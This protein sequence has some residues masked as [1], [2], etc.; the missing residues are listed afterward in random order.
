[1]IVV[2]DRVAKIAWFS[3]PR[4]DEGRVDWVT[5]YSGDIGNTLGPK[6]L[7]TGSSLHVSS[8]KPRRIAAA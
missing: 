2:G 5:D 8:L 4:S 1:L 7:A 3:E 6:G